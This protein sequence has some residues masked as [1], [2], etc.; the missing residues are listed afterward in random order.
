MTP[1]EKMAIQNLLIE[2]VRAQQDAN[3]TLLLDVLLSDQ[4]HAFVLQTLSKQLG[5]VTQ[6]GR[7]L[8]QLLHAFKATNPAL[9][10]P[11]RDEHAA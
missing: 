4:G 1:Q 10:L 2:E 7:M 11:P 3:P 9:S 5:V 8:T 6:N